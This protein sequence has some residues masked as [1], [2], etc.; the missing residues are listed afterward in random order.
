[1]YTNTRVFLNALM[2]VDER[3]CVSFLVKEEARCRPGGILMIDVAEESWAY[4]MPDDKYWK[5]F[6]DAFH[7]GLMM[8][9]EKDAGAHYFVVELDNSNLNVYKYARAD[10]VRRVAEWLSES[11]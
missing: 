10:A 4:L 3:T 8:A 5:R 1:M 2:R 7:D 6:P 11:M 9:I